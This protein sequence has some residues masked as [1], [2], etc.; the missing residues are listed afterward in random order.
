VRSIV[1]GLERS[2][3]I[4]VFVSVAGLAVYFFYFLLCSIFIKKKADRLT[5]MIFDFDVSFYHS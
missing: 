3:V 1:K 2:S 4:N 5:N